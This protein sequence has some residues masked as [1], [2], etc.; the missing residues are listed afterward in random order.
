MQ[1]LMCKVIVNEDKI[2]K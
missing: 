2:I 1:A